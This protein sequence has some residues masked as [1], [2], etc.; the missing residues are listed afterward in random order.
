MGGLGYG[1]DA[2]GRLDATGELD[3]AGRLR[4]RF[5]AAGKLDST[6]GLGLSISGGLELDASAV[7]LRLSTLIGLGLGQSSG[8]KQ[9]FHT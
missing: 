1:V 7:G 9:S 3:A 8:R 2:V 6:S 4:H 5:D